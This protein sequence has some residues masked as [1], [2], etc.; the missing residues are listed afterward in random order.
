MEKRARGDKR[1]ERETLGLAFL[2][3]GRAGSSASM[4][5]RAGRCVG[6]CCGPAEW[7]LKCQCLH[8]CAEVIFPSMDLTAASS[9]EAA[10]PVTKPRV[11][12]PQQDVA[13]IRGGTRN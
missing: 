7:V 1:G 4:A 11:L 5:C 2:P 10:V 13:R 9:A 8:S 12:L 3:D 6:S